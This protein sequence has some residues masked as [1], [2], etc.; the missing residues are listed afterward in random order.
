ML[1]SD[2]AES[3]GGSVLALPVEDVWLALERT[4]E[5]SVEMPKS[6]TADEVRRTFDILEGER[7][8]SYLY[9]TPSI[10]GD[11]RLGCIVGTSGSGKTTMLRDFGT[12]ENAH[13][14]DGRCIADHFDDPFTALGAVGLNSIPAWLR[15]FSALSQGEQY[16]ADLAVALES[17][18][19]VIDEFTSVVD[20]NVARGC[21][22]GVRKF[23]DASGGRLV[24]AT[25][26]RDVI[27]WLTPDWIIDLDLGA[28]CLRPR[29]CLQREP[30]ALDVRRVRRDAWTLF[31]RHHYLSGS[32]HGYAVCYG[33][34]IA[35]DLVGF[36][37]V[38]PFPN[39]ALRNAWR[40][41][42]T[43]VLPEFQGLGIGPALSDAVAAIERGRGHLIYTKAAHPSLVAHR[44]RSPFWTRTRVKAKHRHTPG[45]SSFGRWVENLERDTASHRYVGPGIAA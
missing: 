21:A 4:V 23:L 29:E 40:L 41:T 32:L 16:R 43:V 9:A 3:N 11:W 19:A 13:P 18:D 38:L 31:Q 6:E 27:P 37:A 42:R 33:G 8:S 39:G 28:Y 44:D 14:W 5:L 25:C 17:N 1:A 35:D 12:H 7:L 22:R 45:S 34:F 10:E 26:H 2:R 36:C 24:V 30:L 15:P 20:R